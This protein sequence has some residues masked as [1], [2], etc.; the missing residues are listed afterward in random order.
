[1]SDLSKRLRRSVEMKLQDWY[2]LIEAAD[3]LDRLDPDPVDCGC[4]EAGCPHTPLAQL[5]RAELVRLYRQRIKDVE[6]DR[7]VWLERH[8]ALK[9][10][11]AEYHQATDACCACVWVNKPELHAQV[12]KLLS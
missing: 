11:L 5:P 10:A 6:A 2:L 9:A 1:M 7:N 8:D 4:H 3:E 12:E